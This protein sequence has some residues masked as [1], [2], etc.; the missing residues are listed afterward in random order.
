MLT[1]QLLY[2]DPSELFYHVKQDQFLY[3]FKHGAVSFFNYTPE[4]VSAFFALVQPQCRNFF[5]PPFVDEFIVETNAPENKISFNK[6]EIDNENPETI[7][8]IMLNVSQSVT[9]D[10]YS[11]QTEKLLEETNAYT[12]LLATKGRL[13]ISGRKLTRF[14]GNALLLKNRI[15]ENLYIFDSPPETW[16]NEQLDKLHNDLKKSFDI[17]ERFRDVA[18]GLEIVKDN[19]DLFKDILQYR[20]SLL[21]EWV[22]IIL[23]AIEVINLFVGKA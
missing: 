14:I 7:R 17:Q 21:L 1:G 6:I 3:L 9:L 19:L 13:I 23:I 22:V 12:Q 2:K 16:E 11:D 8:M 15:A 4:E 18:G 5:T 20:T 10:Y